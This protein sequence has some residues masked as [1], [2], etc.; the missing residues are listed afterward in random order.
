MKIEFAVIHPREERY[1]HSLAPRKVL[2]QLGQP[3]VC[4]L[5]AVAK[6]K[7]E[8]RIAGLLVFTLTPDV[9]RL[10]WIYVEEEYRN[11]EIGANLLSIFFDTVRKNKI[12]EAEAIIFGDKL[13]EVSMWEFSGYFLLNG[14]TERSRI[15]MEKKNGGRKE[16]L[17]L[18]ASL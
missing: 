15:F 9:G 4:A 11:R 18:S 8:R 17:L 16:C 7:K 1:I 6:E 5:V 2:A 3:G 13:L 12:P 10:N 14:F